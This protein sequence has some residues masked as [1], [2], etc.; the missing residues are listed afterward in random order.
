M[1][2]PHALKLLIAAIGMEGDDKLIGARFESDGYYGSIRFKGQVANTKGR[3]YS[4]IA[5]SNI[6]VCN[7]CGCFA[8]HSNIA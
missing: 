6:I 5:I 3:P 1:N 7:M 8:V 4:Y 2:F